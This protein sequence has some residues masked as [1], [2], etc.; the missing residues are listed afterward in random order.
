[1]GDKSITKVNSATAPLG[2]HGQKYLAAGLQLSMRFWEQE[3]PGEPKPISA[4]EYETAGFVMEDKAELQ[5]KGQ[6]VLLE[7]GDSCRKTRDTIKKFSKLLP[8]LKQP[9]R[10]RK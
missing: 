8:R 6:T 10:W 5:L 7:K 9:V 2:A 4:R 1:M 3:E